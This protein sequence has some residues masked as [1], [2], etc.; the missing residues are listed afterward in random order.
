MRT[1][2]LSGL[3][4]LVVAAGEQEDCSYTSSCTFQIRGTHNLLDKTMNL[5]GVLQRN[6]ELS[7]TTTGF[8]TLVL[9]AVSPFLKKKT[10]TIVPFMA[11]GTSTHPSFALDFD[12]KRTC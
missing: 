11:I 8:K 4:A 2:C 1:T 6:G 9:K 5:K 3:A 12:A 7:N 10:V